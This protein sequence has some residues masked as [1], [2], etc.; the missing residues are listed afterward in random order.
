MYVILFLLNFEEP[1]EIAMENVA[2]SVTT[3]KASST[4]S[5]VKGNL[6][7]VLLG[8]LRQACVKFQWQITR[9]TLKRTV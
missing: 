2:M 8:V 4:F 7:K 1:N 6:N 5:L 3:P 9:K